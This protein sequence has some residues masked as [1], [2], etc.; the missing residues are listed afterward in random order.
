MKNNSR[1]M[2]ESK[3]NELFNNKSGQTQ[4]SFMSVSMNKRVSSA[5]SK[6]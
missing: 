6:K 4:A 2:R 5:N 3:Q 1:I